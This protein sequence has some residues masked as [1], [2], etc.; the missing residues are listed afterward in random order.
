MRRCRWYGKQFVEVSAPYL[1]ACGATVYFI[2]TPQTGVPEA[3]EM[4]PPGAHWQENEAD[5]PEGVDLEDL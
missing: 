3:F 1:E 4:H 5:M 2:K